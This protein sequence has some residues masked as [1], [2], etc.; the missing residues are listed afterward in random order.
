MGIFR[1]VFCHVNFI[2]GCLLWCSGGSGGT[3]GWTREERKERVE[4]RVVVGEND[5]EK[6]RGT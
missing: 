3:A 5:R 4:R 2:H 1:W 6:G